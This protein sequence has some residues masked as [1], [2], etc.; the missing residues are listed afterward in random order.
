MDRRSFGI[1]ATAAMIWGVKARAAD[2]PSPLDGP[3][4]PPQ[5]PPAKYLIL[6]L[7]GYGSDGADMIDLAADLQPYAPTAAFAAPNA[8]FDIEFGHSWYPIRRLSDGPA[9]L[10]PSAPQGLD[11][12]IKA[13]LARYSLGPE[14]LILIG[15][16]QGASTVLN[17]GLRRGAPPMA[18][19]AF[20]GAGLSP[21]GLTVGTRWPPVMLIQGDKDP[22]VPAGAQGKALRLMKRIGV[23][24]T[25]HMLPGLGHGI[26]GRGIRLAGELIRSATEAAPP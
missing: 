8:P 5:R 9:P 25:A 23:S 16:S 11:A 12:F 17:V 7:H 2:G 24:A 18:I 22:R 19:V 13:E 20:S 26:D 3:R 6:L 1:A 14:R 15:F 21:D 10:E 4:R